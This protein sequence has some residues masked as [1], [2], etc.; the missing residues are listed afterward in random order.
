MLLF[1]ASVIVIDRITNL[2]VPIV[3]FAISDL[4][5]YFVILSSS[6]GQSTINFTLPPATVAP[7][8][9]KRSLVDPTIEVGYGWIWFEAKRSK[10]AYVFTLC[11]FLINW[12]LTIGSIYI[13]LLVASRREK[14]DT[15]ILFLPLTIV[16]ILMALR[17][18]YAGAPPFGFYIGKLWVLKP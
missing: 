18:L 1:T 14:V 16:L 9:L 17:G 8:Q 12:A 11:L 4:K 2:S 7:A 15:T 10:F 6:W 3:G 5:N 13:T